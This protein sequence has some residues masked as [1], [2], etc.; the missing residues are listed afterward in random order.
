MVGLIRRNICCTSMFRRYVIPRYEQPTPQQLREVSTL[1]RNYNPL[2]SMSFTKP[3]SL[4]LL[5]SYPIP[6][7]T[8]MNPA[9]ELHPQIRTLAAKAAAKPAKKDDGSTGSDAKLSYWDQKKATKDR[10]REIFFARQERK[11]RVKVRRAG[12]PK[13]TKKFEFH[14]FYLQKKVTD[15]FSSFT[16]GTAGM[17]IA[18]AKL[19]VCWCDSTVVEYD[20]RSNN[21]NQAAYTGCETC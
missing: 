4:L 18:T 5:H 3:Q 2:S 17:I 19:T 20:F 16:Y 15:E 11:E 13:D 1:I 9:S 7:L 10:R 12:K 21:F 6:F 8:P 14:A